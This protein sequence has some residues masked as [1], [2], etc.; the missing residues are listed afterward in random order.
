MAHLVIPSHRFGSVCPPLHPGGEPHDTSRS[1][2]YRQRRRPGPGYCLPC[3]IFLPARAG[4][5]AAP[6]ASEPVNSSSCRRRHCRSGRRCSR[7]SAL[8][9]ENRHAGQVLRACPCARTARLRRLRLLLAR[10]QVFVS[11]RTAHRHCSQCSPST[12]P[13][14][15][16]LTLMPCLI[17]SSPA[18]CVSADHRRLG[19]AVDRH[20]RSRRAARLARHVDD[21]AALAARD[22][23]PRGRLHREQ[24]A[25]DVD[26]EEPV[27]ARLR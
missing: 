12:T 26:G 10:L 7:L 4:E 16:A 5:R 19:G 20:Q 23:R 8:A 6:K 22:H 13:G 2:Q 18:D 17:R 11:W 15:I 25:G 21:L 14:A 1:A 27:V 9:Q 24:R 3:R